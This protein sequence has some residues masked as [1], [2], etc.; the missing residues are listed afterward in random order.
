MTSGGRE[1]T[2]ASA[3]EARKKAQARSNRMAPILPLRARD[4]HALDQDRAARAAAALEHITA[5][6]D[7]ALEHVAQVAGDG[8]LLDRELDLAAVH[9][10]AGGAARV[11]TRDQVDAVAEQLGHE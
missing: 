10:V 5:H 8:D 9:P 6:G 7:D 3:L 11:V 1:A 2:C 4:R